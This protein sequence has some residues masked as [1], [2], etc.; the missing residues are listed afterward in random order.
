LPA[1]RSSAFNDVE[2]FE[3]AF[4]GTRLNLLLLGP[5]RFEARV[6]RIALPQFTLF[7]CSEN[8]P[9]IAHIALREHTAGLVFPTAEN[10]PAR[11]AGVDLRI[12]EVAV[13]SPGQRFHLC[14][15]P[16][17]SW[18]LVLFGRKELNQW[19]GSRRVGSCV[20]RL[21]PPHPAVRRLL[22]LH[23]RSVH[24]TMTKPELV[25][26]LGPASEL[27]QALKQTLALCITEG[28]LQKLRPSCHNHSRII[29]RFEDVLQAGAWRP[30]RSSGFAALLGVSTRTLRM[31]CQ[32]HLGMSP[33]RYVRLWRLNMARRRLLRSSPEATTV[34]EIAMQCGFPEL[35][36]FAVVFRR[37]FGEAPSTTLRNASVAINR[38]EELPFCAS[39]PSHSFD[40]PYAS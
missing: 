39:I 31:C 37:T 6:T 23:G 1:S 14:M 32:E 40:E 13:L 27:E 9:A 29:E 7:G 25:S 36:R 26:D 24:T 22:R 21:A 5:G 16:L 15:P 18:G 11:A 17:F 28:T 35:G 8:L 34:R 12:G 2:Q 38:G 19:L 30:L 33:D 20:A 4:L 10:R 3:A